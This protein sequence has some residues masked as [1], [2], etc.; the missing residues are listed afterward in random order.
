MPCLFQAVSAR[1]QPSRPGEGTPRESSIDPEL[2]FLGLPSQFSEAEL[3]QCTPMLAEM[4]DRLREGQ[5]RDSLDK[6]RV[7][8]HV[9]SRMLSFKKRNVRHQQPN[10]R[11]QKQLASNQSKVIQH[12]EKYQ[13]AY[14]AKLSLSGR[15]EWQEKWRVLNKE[16]VR[17]LSTTDIADNPVEGPSHGRR[18][19]SWIWMSADSDGSGEEAGTLSG[20]H[21]GMYRSF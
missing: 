5:L 10:T 13:A 11:A 20:M 14:S 4:E 12:A 17:P 16:H 18:A 15:G 3:S 19:V 2:W 9:Q 1:L 21:E 6:L 8:L 7:Q